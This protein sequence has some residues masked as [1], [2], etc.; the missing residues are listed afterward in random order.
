[1]PSAQQEAISQ[2]QEDED[3]AEIKTA[4]ESVK[5]SASSKDAQYYGSV[6]GQCIPRNNFVHR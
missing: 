5:S 2:V 4:D 6:S 3:L 1:M